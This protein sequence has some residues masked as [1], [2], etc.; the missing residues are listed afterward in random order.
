MKRFFIL[1][2][3][4]ILYL[5]WTDV[6]FRDYVSEFTCAC[7]SWDLRETQMA[8][9]SQ[10]DP[11]GNV[12]V[13]GFIVV[14]SYACRAASLCICTYRWDQWWES[15]SSSSLQLSVVCYISPHGPFLL[16]FGSS[17]PFI[18]LS[19]LGWAFSWHALWDNLGTGKNM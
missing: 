6:L 11:Q 9:S 5:N 16:R 3:C 2:I 7:R 17:V 4:L 1:C 18:H 13:S 8:Q 10:K 14:N 19:A 12:F 15:S